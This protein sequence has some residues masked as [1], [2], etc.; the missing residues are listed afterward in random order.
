MNK[1]TKIV[2]T[3]LIIVLIL[4]LI[5]CFIILT[6]KNNKIQTSYS[7]DINSID[8][9]GEKFYEDLS[10]VEFDVSGELE[11]V[12]SEN[13]IFSG[14]YIFP[15]SSE[16]MIDYLYES[17]YSPELLDIA[18]NEIFARH[19]HDFSNKELKEYFESKDWYKPIKGK[20]VAVS[21]LNKIEQDNVI[22]LEKCIKLFREEKYSDKYFEVLSK[23]FMNGYDEKIINDKLIIREYKELNNY[24]DR[25]S[26]LVYSLNGSVEITYD[27]GKVIYSYFGFNIFESIYTDDNVVSMVVVGSHEAAELYIY[28]I[29]LKENK[30]MSDKELINL[31]SINYN[32]EDEYKGEFFIN[33]NGNIC[34]IKR[35]DNYGDLGNAYDY[36][37]GEKIENFYDD[38]NKDIENYTKEEN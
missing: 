6:L 7:G 13:T 29:D 12:K 4:L 5:T 28:N 30:M 14:D 2:I 23:E 19:G 16:K 37:T 10:K 20:K 26:E 18:K 31:Y 11:D 17:K 38:L 27:N 9:S 8:E 24:I 15:E 21:E 3:A 1:K 22:F 34:F 35:S 36:N 32:N 25:V 33:E